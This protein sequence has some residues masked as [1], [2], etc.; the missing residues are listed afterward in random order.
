MDNFILGYY[1]SPFHWVRNVE[2]GSR[3]YPIKITTW[4]SYK[5]FC[6]D[7]HAEIVPGNARNIDLRG[8]V[9]AAAWH[10]HR[11]INIQEHLA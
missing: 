3:S 1:H 7:S 11:A 9:Y 6:S 10:A 2:L 5:N 4:L 8:K